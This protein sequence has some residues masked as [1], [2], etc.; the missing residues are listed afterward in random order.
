MEL[1]TLLGTKGREGFKGLSEEIKFD[2]GFKVKYAL[3]RRKRE[4]R[5]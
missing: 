2:V 1:L 5:L 3:T 4:L